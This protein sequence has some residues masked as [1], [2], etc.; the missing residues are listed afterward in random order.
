[1]GKFF[2]TIEVKDRHKMKIYLEKEKKK[3]KDKLN[4]K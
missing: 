2:K 3:T 1:M 4:V